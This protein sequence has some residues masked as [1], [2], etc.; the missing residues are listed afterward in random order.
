MQTA[1]KLTTT[2]QQGGKIEVADAQLPAG[3]E[4]EIIVLFPP[5]TDGPPR[6]VVDVLADAPGQ[7]AFRSAE[8][9]DAYLRE[10]RDAWDR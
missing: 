8:E 10:E 7:L 3:K 9:V 4:V 2:V 5:A 1:I 6:S